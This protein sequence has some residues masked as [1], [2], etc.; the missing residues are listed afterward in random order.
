ME[1][2]N[3]ILSE[4]NKKK[5]VE[6]A[7]ELLPTR[8]GSFFGGLDYDNYY[9]QELEKTKKIIEKLLNVKNLGEYDIEYTSSW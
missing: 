6:L 4:K 7:K 2:I 9:F 5:R 1:I 3:E 8:E